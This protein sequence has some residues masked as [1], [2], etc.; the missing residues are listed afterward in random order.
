[1]KRKR[2]GTFG[3]AERIFSGKNFS[4]HFKPMSYGLVGENSRIQGQGIEGND[5]SEQGKVDNMCV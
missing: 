2:S 4:I 5:P 1:M 3:D